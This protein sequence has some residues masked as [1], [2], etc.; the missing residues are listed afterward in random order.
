MSIRDNLKAPKGYSCKIN[1]RRSKDDIADSYEKLCG[2]LEAACRRIERQ[3]RII[4]KLEERKGQD[5]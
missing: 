4:E 3:G 2:K 5:E 1:R